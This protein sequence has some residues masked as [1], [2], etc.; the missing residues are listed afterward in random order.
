MRRQW[1]P[2]ECDADISGADKC[3]TT[4]I[5]RIDPEEYYLFLY[6]QKYTSYYTDIDPKNKFHTNLFEISNE[7]F[8]CEDGVKYSKNF[9][10]MRSSSKRTC[11]FTSFL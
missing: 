9:V 8:C 2:A 4:E 7:F 6:S 11:I 3:A 5:L 10:G 1:C